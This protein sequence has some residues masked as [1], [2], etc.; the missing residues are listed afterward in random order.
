[1]KRFRVTCPCCKGEKE[2]VVAGEGK[3]P[4][5]DI[6]TIFIDLQTCSHCEGTGNVEAEVEEGTCP[7]T[8]S[9]LP[10]KDLSEDTTK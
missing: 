7:N 9:D 6:P 10:P 2:L 1:M 5:V 8:K 3:I 4:G